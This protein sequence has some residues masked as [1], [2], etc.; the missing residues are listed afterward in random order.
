MPYTLTIPSGYRARRNYCPRCPDANADNRCR[1]I[2][3]LHPYCPEHRGYN[4]DVLTEDGVYPS[5]CPSCH[6]A[7]NRPGQV[8]GEACEYCETI[9]QRETR[10]Q[11]A[12]A[13]RIQ[14][15][16]RSVYAVRMPRVGD[17]VEIIHS[18][19][20]IAD[21]LGLRGIVEQISG[22]DAY[23]RPITPRP[24][25]NPD[26]YL[27]HSELWWQIANL[28]VVRPSALERERIAR[29]AQE[30]ASASV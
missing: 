27:A 9:E 18:D 2:T 11:R 22:T 23:I 28:A 7:V 10:L 1:H 8:F 20:G 6:A 5:R 29:E 19:P 15:M 4:R 26:Y 25:Y 21:W 30:D 3:D 16:D 13:E 17:T 14:Q 24:D 12:R